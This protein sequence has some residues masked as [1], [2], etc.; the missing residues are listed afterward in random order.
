MDWLLTMK[1]RRFSETGDRC[2]SL[3]KLYF[4]FPLV[5]NSILAIPL[6]ISFLDHEFFEEPVYWLFLLFEI[7]CTFM[8]ISQNHWR[9]WILEEEF[10]HVNTFGIKRR[11]AYK[12]V[13]YIKTLKTG[14]KLI[15][16]EHKAI[17]FV[18]DKYA[19]GWDDFIKVYNRKKLQLK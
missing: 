3:P 15:K 8:A 2:V 17:P 19:I 13:S 18:V 7:L 12:D 14:D 5:S 16:I 10:I 9:L 6:V 4:Y 1:Q 11:F